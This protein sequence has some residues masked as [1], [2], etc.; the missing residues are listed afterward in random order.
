MLFAIPS[1][2]IGAIMIMRTFKGQPIG[3]GLWLFFAL[4]IIFPCEPKR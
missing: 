4:V 3:W 2:I 1:L